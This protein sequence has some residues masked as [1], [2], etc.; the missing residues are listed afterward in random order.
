MT[1]KW[2]HFDHRCAKELRNDKEFTDVTLVCSVQNA[3]SHR[4]VLSTNSKLFN[5][6]LKE[7]KGLKSL[8]DQKLKAKGLTLTILNG[9][10]GT[11]KANELNKEKSEQI[12]VKEVKKANGDKYK[13][14]EPAER[15]KKVDVG[16]IDIINQ[17]ADSFSGTR[18]T[19]NISTANGIVDRHSL[20]KVR[21]K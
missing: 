17:L 20:K 8:I 14:E 21:S 9:L 3:E 6:K 13:N 12:K 18:Q 5:K 16:F 4:V 7:K 15:E 19:K 11:G 1:L 2:N 10:K